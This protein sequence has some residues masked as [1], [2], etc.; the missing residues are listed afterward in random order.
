MNCQIP[1]CGVD[2]GGRH[3]KADAPDVVAAQRLA[4]RRLDLIAPEGPEGVPLFR[5]V[6]EREAGALEQAL[7]DV[8][9][10][11]RE[12]HGQQVEATPAGRPV[13]Q[14]DALERIRIEQVGK[15]A[16]GVGEV[17][18]PTLVGP[19]FIGLGSAP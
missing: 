9:V 10:V 1:F 4:H 5:D 15:V 2:R 11:G 7:P 17:D 6:R 3:G 16:D 19:S 18:E 8:D 12:P 13:E 14:G